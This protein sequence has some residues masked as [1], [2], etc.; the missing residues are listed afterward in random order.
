MARLRTIPPGE[1]LGAW[2]IAWLLSLSLG[3]QIAYL[4]SKTYRF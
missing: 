4:V 1:A 2:A 3:F